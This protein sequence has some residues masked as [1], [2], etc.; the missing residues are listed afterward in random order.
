MHEGY[1]MSKWEAKIRHKPP[2]VCRT[3]PIQILIPKDARGSNMS[4][5]E[6]PAQ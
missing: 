3:S 6:G 2:T 4:A 5:E 1:E